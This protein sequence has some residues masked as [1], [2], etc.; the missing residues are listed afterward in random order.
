MDANLG[1]I[2]D[3]ARIKRL[4][5]VVIIAALMLAVVLVQRD[6]TR[7]YLV[8]QDALALVLIVLLIDFG[9]KIPWKLAGSEKLV[10]QSRMWQWQAIAGIFLLLAG[11]A[12]HHWIMQGYALSRDEQMVL[13]DVAIFESGHWLAKIP[14]VWHPYFEALNSTFLLRVPDNS[15]WASAYLPV[16]ALGHLM[17]EKLT[18]EAAL[19]PPFATAVGFAGLW[20]IMDM[21]WPQ[22]RDVKIAGT[23][24]YVLSAQILAASMTS[25][26]M[27]AHLGLSNLWLA[28]YIKNRWWSHALALLI[29]FAATG[30]HQ[31][32]F[33][34]LLAMPFIV[35]LFWQR[36]YAYGAM[37][38]VAYGAIGLFWAGW[39]A[40]LLA[41]W[42]S[43]GQLGQSQ[44]VVGFASVAIG[45]LV[46]FKLEN[47]GLMGANLLRLI[48]WN[49][50]LLLPLFLV[51]G[52]LAW[53][54]R[55]AL[56]LAMVASVFCTTFAML[57]LLA[58][59]GHGWGY[60]Y[61]HAHIGMI[62]LIALGGFVHFADRNW[63]IWPNIWRTACVAS[64]ALLALHLWQ[65][66]AMVAPYATASRAIDAMDADVVIIDNRGAPFADDLVLNRPDLSNRPIRLALSAMQDNDIQKLCDKYKIQLFGGPNHLG[67]IRAL[68]GNTPTPVEDNALNS[69]W[70]AM[71]CPIAPQ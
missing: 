19:F 56:R 36:R 21:L 48:S 2:A 32:I 33:H 10:L 20:W 61:L 39:F 8:W 42:S 31:L 44:G 30:L 62:I 16:N 67:F 41:P 34:P 1:V 9:Y 51:G 49:H 58:Y 27:A 69:R 52:G 47:I 50:A 57:A 54:T 45:L 12:G 68:F 29:G 6:L 53:K 59:Q 64:L 25:Y 38:G 37:Y 66:R 17:M 23:L 70:M 28:L 7:W 46:D 14:N 15:V 60:R 35:L 3:W 71:R 4:S 55:N 5:V 63:N 18:G 26:A 65:A 22:R 11:W 43:A 24:F 40:G 13:F